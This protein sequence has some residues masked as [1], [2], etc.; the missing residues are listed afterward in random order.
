MLED[1][2]AESGIDLLEILASEVEEPLSNFEVSEIYG[3]ETDSEPLE[4][5]NGYDGDVDDYL[6]DFVDDYDIAD[7]EDTYGDEAL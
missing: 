4:L 1:L 3:E 7:A 5:D 6:D 2:A